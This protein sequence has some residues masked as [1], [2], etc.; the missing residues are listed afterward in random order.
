MKKN[1]LS[2]LGT[3]LVLALCML[4]PSGSKAYNPAEAPTTTTICSN[5][6]KVHSIVDKLPEFPGG[7]Q[8]MM[9]FLQSEIKYPKECMEQKQEGRT[10]V[11]FV[12]NKKGKLTKIKVLKSSGYKLLDKE[13][14]RA[15]K[16]MPKWIPGEH[17]GKVVNVQMTLPVSFKLRGR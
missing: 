5:D 9:K 8:E 13:A 12:V 16:Q 7:M 17:E 4:H 3:T 2:I 15:V 1:T 6:N 11:N 10:M 14:I